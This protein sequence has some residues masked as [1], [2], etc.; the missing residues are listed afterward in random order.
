VLCGIKRNGDSWDVTYDPDNCPLFIKIPRKSCNDKLSQRRFNIY[1]FVGIG[2]KYNIIPG[3]NNETIKQAVPY[4]IY[5]MVDARGNQF[6]SG[7]K[8]YAYGLN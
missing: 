1:K 3:E 2:I 4:P 8:I 5:A 7:N 6:D